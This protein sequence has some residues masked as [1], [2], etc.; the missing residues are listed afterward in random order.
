MAYEK[1]ALEKMVLDASERFLFR[2]G[3]KNLNLNDIAREINISKTTIYKTFDSKYEVA[4]QVI[5]RLLERTDSAMLELLRSD[6]SLPEKLTKGAEIIATIY[7]K[8]DREFL[9]DLE[10]SL[11]ELWE[12]IDEARKNKE[13][14]LAALLRQEQEKGV[15]R[16]DVD[17]SLLAA[18]MLTLIRGMYNP[19]FLLAHH[20]T[21]ELVCKVIV[22]LLL[23]GALNTASQN[24]KDM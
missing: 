20:T 19:T 16:G 11:P 18:A 8:M 17:P 23:Q 21:S 6:L 22:D 14:L 12:K 13:I 5:N 1:A 2:Y 24:R 7:T 10:S 15:V 9:R 3:Y 4:T